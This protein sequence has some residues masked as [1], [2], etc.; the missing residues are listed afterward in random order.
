M[1]VTATK[2]S[3]GATAE[4]VSLELL[5]ATQDAGM[6]VVGSRGAGRFARLLM[7]SVSCQVTHHAHCPVVVIP[8]EYYR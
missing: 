1:P 5:T 8:A 3:P 7:G 4:I 2:E 6:I